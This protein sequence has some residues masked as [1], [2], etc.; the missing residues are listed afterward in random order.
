MSFSFIAILILIPINPIAVFTCAISSSTI[1]SAWCPALGKI[2]AVCFSNAER[3]PLSFP[4]IVIWTPIAPPSMIC[5]NVHIVALLNAVPRSIWEAILLHITPG[6]NSG[7]SISTTEICGFFN[8]KS[9]ASL[10]VRALIPVPFLPITIPGLVT[11][12]ATLVPI[13]VFEISACENPASLI[14]S[15]R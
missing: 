9:V 15:L 13:G 10:S 14:A 7:F 4:E 5:F 6:T 12:N 3:S 1:T 8:P 11:C 2:P